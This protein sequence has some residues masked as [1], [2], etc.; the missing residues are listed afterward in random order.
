MQMMHTIQRCNQSDNQHDKRINSLIPENEISNKSKNPAPDYD[1]RT[2]KLRIRR[3]E[4]SR[5][6]LLDWAYTY[7]T[8][9]LGLTVVQR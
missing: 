5:E 1:E 6:F 7:I 9:T 4:V 2:V 8:G 3:L